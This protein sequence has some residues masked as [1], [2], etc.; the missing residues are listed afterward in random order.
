[1]QSNAVPSAGGK[2]FTL[3][4]RGNDSLSLRAGD[5]VKAEVLGVKPDNTATIRL[6]N[7]VLE[8]KAEVPVQ[9]GDLLTLRV[10]RQ[11]NFVYLRLAGSAS[12]TADPVANAILPALKG[13]QQLASG[14]EGMARLVNLL[15]QL[16]PGLRES[17]PEIEV[18]ERFLLTMD[19]MSGQA[20]KD[21]VQDGGVFFETKLRILAHGMEAE[22]TAS[23]AAARHIIA[24]DLKAALLRLKD[25]VLQQGF[26]DNIAQKG[27]NGRELLDTLDG[28][29]K[30]IEFYQLQSKLTESIQF[31]LPLF[32]KG[33]KDGELVMRESD[34]GPGERSFSCSL[35]LDLERAGRVQA[36]LLLQK[37]ALHVNCAAEREDLFR[38]LQENAGIIEGQ[39]ESSGLRLGSLAIRHEK[40]ID[41]ETHRAAGISIRA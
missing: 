39:F 22:G 41:F 2:G 20:L 24:G 12:D 32:W 31:F 19:Q 17:M 38:L 14:V 33:L 1:M 3:Y 37:G 6:N 4:I 30:N 40:A 10:E 11:E 35:H 5:V 27:I 15:K 28:V 34:R 23:D 16:P 26:L 13:L 21:A 36:N 18:A 9:K 29:L 8:V 7:M 25:T